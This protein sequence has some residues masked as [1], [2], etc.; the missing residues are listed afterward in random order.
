MRTFW[1]EK[2]ETHGIAGASTHDMCKDFRGEC[3]YMA[4]QD[5]HFPELTVRETLSFA[6]ATQFPKASAYGAAKTQLAL[7]VFNLA[8]AVDTKIGNEVIRGVSG[9]EKKRVTI[10]EALSAEASIQCWDNST[11]GMDSETALSIVR[12]FRSL[13]KN[14]GTAMVVSLY[15]ASQLALD[16]FDL[17]TVL[18]Q[19][20]QIYFGSWNAG[21]SY[22]QSLGFQ[23]PPKMTAGDFFTA[24]TNPAE[25]RKLAQEGRED[26]VPITAEDFVFHW[27]LSAERTWLL[28]EVHAFQEEFPSGRATLDALRKMKASSRGVNLCVF[29]FA[30]WCVYANAVPSH[31]SSPYTIGTFRQI[32]LCL[33]RGI[34]RVKNNIQLPI[35]TVLGNTIMALIV[36]SIF[37]NLKPDSDSMQK[38]TILLFF[39][40]LLNGF[41]TGFEVFSCNLPGFCLANGV[42]GFAV[43]QQRPICEKHRRYAFYH[44]FAEAVSAMLCDL[45][46]K[47]SAT[48]LFNVVLYFMTN[49]RREPSAFFIYLLF[50]F[51]TLMTMSM[52]FRGIASMSRTM[53]QSMVPMGILTI[54]FVIYTG[55]VIPEDYMHPWL[56]WCRYVNPVYYSFQSVM[57]NE[58]S[59]Y[60]SAA[61]CLLQ[62]ANTPVVSRPRILLQSLHARG[63]ELQRRAGNMRQSLCYPRSPLRGWYPVSVPRL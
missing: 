4:E 15:Q 47:L 45:P 54:L 17:V 39:S 1:Q 24:L 57:I 35:S 2:H 23:K 48:V 37:F 56:S 51:T 36:G 3:V 30:L 10:A 60:N 19:G 29:I 20:R 26:T 33:G 13:A 59:R 52:F 50:I 5:V 7:D 9:G 16:E 28:G 31:R 58:V 42:Q 27:N 32:G 61:A 41:M 49:L 8:D 40:T 53:H 44:P 62:R 21:L 14:Q 25:A 22:F 55:F 43:W 11:R 63:P 12:H 38:R 34:Q 18:Y 6:S 46:A